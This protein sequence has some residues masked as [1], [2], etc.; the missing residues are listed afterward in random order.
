VRR[1]AVSDERQIVLT[2]EQWM[3]LIN[4][5]GESLRRCCANVSALRD[6]IIGLAREGGAFWSYSG[7]RFL[8]AYRW[9]IG[10]H[11]ELAEEPTIKHIVET[12]CKALGRDIPTLENKEEA[13]PEICVGLSSGERECALTRLTHVSNELNSL[14]RAIENLGHKGRKG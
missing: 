13:S 10:S 8:R 2:P 4:A 1:R 9:A 11:P 3:D 7:E 14:K 5:D 6:E 12:I